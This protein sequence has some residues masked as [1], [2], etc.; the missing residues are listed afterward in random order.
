MSYILGSLDQTNF[1]TSMS[2]K[3]AD[4]FN[5]VLDGPVIFWL[6]FSSVLLAVKTP[7]LSCP[8]WWPLK[9]L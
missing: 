3:L 4:I 8:W 1:E 6:F 2:S 5:H 9:L 7:S